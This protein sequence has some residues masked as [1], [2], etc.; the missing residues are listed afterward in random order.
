V[1]KIYLAFSDLGW[2]R[3]LA[4]TES[5]LTP[6]EAGR[7]LVSYYYLKSLRDDVDPAATV[8]RIVEEGFR[9]PPDLFLDSGGFSAWSRGAVVDLGDY[10]EFVR[11]SAG[12]WS[13]VATLDVIGDAAATAANTHRMLDAL[14]A[15]PIYPVFHV[16]SDWKWLRYW[17]ERSP[18]ICLGGMVPYTG[19]PRLLRAWLHKCFQIIP[20]RTQV[21][22]LG[23]TVLSLLRLFHF[24]SVDSSSWVV[25]MRYGQHRLFDEERATFV[26]TWGM[27]TTV[28]R[29]D[30][31]ARYGRVDP[32]TEHDEIAQLSLESWYRAEVWLR[33][34][35]E[36]QRERT[37]T[38]HGPTDGLALGGLQPAQDLADPDGVAQALDP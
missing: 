13:I 30:L 3:R 16:G 33:G 26:P 14:P 28:P 2:L 22:G 36:R 15:E 29:R 31:L 23:L 35:W 5:P 20:P 10:I 25:G 11:R 6:R 38:D 9:A 21:H 37:A 8:A 19:R 32:P 1:T 24:T 7:V 17:V 27:S 4:A 12:R 34:Y 18:R